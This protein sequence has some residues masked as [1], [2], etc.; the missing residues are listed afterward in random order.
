MSKINPGVKLRLLQDCGYSCAVCQVTA[1]PR[2]FKDNQ[3]YR[4]FDESGQMT[5][6]AIT[7]DHIVPKSKG[8]TNR[9]IN[10]IVMCN[11]CNSE[12]TDKDPIQWLN[13]LDP[14]IRK[15][16]EKHVLSAVEFHSETIGKNICDHCIRDISSKKKIDPYA[17]NAVR[18]VNS[19]LKKDITNFFVKLLVFWMVIVPLT[20]FRMIMKSTGQWDNFINQDKKNERT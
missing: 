12:K 4:V 7:V 6:K 19:L 5:K 10:L 13:S 15:R 8:G 20:L 2:L 16:V 18:R 9:Q 14:E 11:K 17:R 1:M 3:G